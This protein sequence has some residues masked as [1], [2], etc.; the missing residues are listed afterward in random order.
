MYSFLALLSGV[1]IA[2]ML[3]MNGSLGVRF[4]V[5]HAALYTH[6]VGSVFGFFA[7]FLTNKRHSRSVR[8]IPVWM[9]SGGVI[10]VA[11]TVCN[12][13][14]FSHISLTSIIALGLFAQLVFSW[15]IDS[16]GW[17][18]MV[19]QKDKGASIPAVLLSAA[20]IVLMLD[21]PTAGGFWYVLFSLAAGVT[22]VLSRTVNARLSEHT[23]ALEGSLINHLAGLPFCLLLAFLVPET[24]VPGRFTLW[25]WLGGVL[26]VATVVLCN[27][28]V[29][30]IPAYRLTLLSFC[31]QLFCGILFDLLGGSAL[32]ERE[33]AAGLLV[34]AGIAAGQFS[35]I[36]RQRKRKQ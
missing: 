36:R 19:R 5:Y 7:L 14:A 1:V 16:F 34:A 13:L 28:T 10:G 20:G 35:A 8:K 32:N 21:T 23:G 33:F 4:G 12:N 18:G 27:I 15:L 2:V 9:Y 17:F 11:T 6:I 26:G 30:K 3:Q 31:G 24:A 22:V 29:P 25:P